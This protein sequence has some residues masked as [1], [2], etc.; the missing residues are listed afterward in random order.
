[1]SAIRLAL[2]VLLR[3]RIWGYRIILAA[4]SVLPPSPWTDEFY[5]RIS[6]E[7]RAVVLGGDFT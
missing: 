4:D 7:K 6:H 5:V 3:P 1:M 2:F